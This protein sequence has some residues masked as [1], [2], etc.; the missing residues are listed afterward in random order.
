MLTQKL[1]T[2]LDQVAAEAS[3]TSAEALQAL[4][5]H[6]MTGGTDR[7]GPVRDIFAALGD[8]WSTLILLVLRTGE[9]RHALLRRIMDVL[10]HEEGV[11]QR[12]LTL[13]LR[14]LERNGLVRRAITGD[15]PPHVSYSL[16]PLAQDLLAHV[17]GLIGWIIDNRAAIEAARQDYDLRQEDA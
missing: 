5:A 13:K 7:H 2:L 4:A 6:M 17:W 15:V 8:R 10:G 11:S 3:D 12:M 9:Y 16:T 1:E 14:A